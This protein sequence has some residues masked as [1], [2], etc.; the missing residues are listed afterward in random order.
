MNNPPK[1]PDDLNK[2]QIDFFSAITKTFLFTEDGIDYQ[3]D[4]YPID[5]V[6]QIIPLKNLSGKERLLT[7]NQQYW[8]RLFS[9]MQSEFPLLCNLLNYEAF[10]KLISHYLDENSSESFSLT[11]LSNRLLDFL[12]NSRDWTQYPILLEATELELIHIESFDALQL[13][14]ELQLVPMTVK[15]IHLIESKGLAFQPSC[16]LFHEHWNLV[17]SRHQAIEQLEEEEDIIELEPL[18]E[19]S[20]WC[21]FRKDNIVEEEQISFIQYELLSLLKNGH[22]LNDALVSIENSATE[23]D[24]ILIEK[25]LS[26]W[27]ARWVSLGWFVLPK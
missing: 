20:F 4:S 11:N 7:Y 5:L 14:N 17:F 22:S 6:E 21:I 26:S 8:F 13:S 18:L 2:Y 15:E 9:T 3:M 25:N 19:E 24:L 23:Q 1:S 12:K 27:F 16:T 10:N